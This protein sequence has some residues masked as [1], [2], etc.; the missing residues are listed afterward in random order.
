MQ[1]HNQGEPTAP[2]HF[3]NVSWLLL[4][5]VALSVLAHGLS[6]LLSPA[7]EVQLAEHRFGATL[8]ST[9]LAPAK[10]QPTLQP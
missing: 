3:P 10:D 1:F 9:V 5:F 8:I 4:A 2:A 7:H 6:L